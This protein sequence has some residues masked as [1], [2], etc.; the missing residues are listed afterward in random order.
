VWLC[1]FNL[2][3]DPG[4]VHPAGDKEELYVDVG[5]YG[6]PKVPKGKQ[7]HAVNT[8]REIE[9]FVAKVNG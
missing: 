5:I 1:P 6:V 9:D 7:F 3:N 2:P 4:M 8:T